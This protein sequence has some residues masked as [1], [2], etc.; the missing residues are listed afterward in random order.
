MKPSEINQKYQIHW[1][2]ETI[3]DEE[4]SF[5]ILIDL[6]EICTVQDCIMMALK[7][8]NKVLQIKQVSYSLEENPQL[9]ELFIAKKN[10]KPK[11]DYPCKFSLH[12]D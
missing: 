12:Y 11:E 5:S 10:G 2:A 8:L 9:Y 7:E 6:P 4:A 1:C 3:F